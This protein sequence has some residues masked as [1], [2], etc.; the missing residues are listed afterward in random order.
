MPGPVFRL[1]MTT[2]ARAPRTY[3]LRAL[4]GL[5]LL[6]FVALAYHDAFSGQGRRAF[7]SGGEVSAFAR[8]LFEGLVLAQG[9]AVVLL[10][11]ALAA[12][13]VAGEAQRKTLDELLTTSLSAG[14]VV[15]DKAAARLARVGA[16]ILSG[17]PVLLVSADLGGYGPAA[18]IVALGV[19]GSTAFFLAG[20]A[21][22]ASTQTRSVRASMNATMTIGL[23]WLIVPAAVEV[24]LP[25]AGAVGFALFPWVE[26]I[27]AWAAA[28]SPFAVW[29]QFA[30]GAIRTPE[31]LS[32]TLAGMA[33]LQI[34][35]GIA[36]IVLASALLRPGARQSFPAFAKAG[37]AERPRPAI[38][39][40]G[41][42][43][44]LWKE[45]IVPRVPAFY[46]PVALV[47]GLAL[48]AMLLC[49]T[50]GY[51][52]SA[53][54]ET[55][56]A[57]YGLAPS[58][59]ARANFLLYL[60]IVAT[61]IALVYL[62]GVASDAA[63]SLTAEREKD[64]WVSLV[65]TPLTGTEIVRAKF[66]SAIWGI[67]H[68]VVAFV[69]LVVVGMIAGSVHPLATPLLLAEFTAFSA[70]AAALGVWVSLRS[71]ST[72]RA[73]GFTT[74][75]LVAVNASGLLISQIPGVPRPLAF[76]GCAPLG[77]AVSLV[78]HG[79][80]AGTPS[81]GILG[82]LSDEDLSRAWTDS[83]GT[84]LAA[85]LLG[86]VAQG[87]GAFLLFRSTCRG[88]DKALDRPPVEAPEALETARPA[89]QAP[90]VTRLPS[91]GRSAAVATGLGNLR[92]AR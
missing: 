37:K 52:V 73:L 60:R 35:G 54:R 81:F 10:A 12:G 29:L 40:C 1:E 38:P 5:G 23:T 87:L 2:Q 75:I 36:W 62:L 27:N 84:V 47:T 43:P 45:L 69:G 85:C 71:R 31:R 26:P 51:A 63:A 13:A 55:L 6:L 74:L 56:A 91:R 30:S 25:R 32:A 42:D 14:E 83:R 65:T 53:L 24:L 11:P 19:T 64:T 17:L 49:S 44:M 46:R 7:Y 34:L 15:A 92:R 50:F 79:D 22:L 41:A 82:L 61:G 9:M 16:L 66:L 3:V 68:T 80:V 18:A 4:Y 78:S 21:L 28:S 39:P 33:A 48:G 59:S 88:F 58:G 8:R 20:L 72:T 76:A 89:T 86:T 70:F 67:R 77:V 90:L 57:G